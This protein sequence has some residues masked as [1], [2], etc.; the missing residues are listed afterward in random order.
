MSGYQISIRPLMGRCKE[1]KRKPGKADRGTPPTV[2]LI[3]NPPI[4][5]TLTMTSITPFLWF[6]NN[7][8]QAV[9]FY[10]SV[11][12]NA[13]AIASRTS[14]M[15]FVLRSRYSGENRR[16]LLRAP[17]HS[18]DQGCSAVPTD[19]SRRHRRCQSNHH[20]TSLH[21]VSCIASPMPVTVR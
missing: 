16:P 8:P 5:K 18:Y 14:G 17:G 2:G 11:F 1:T 13:K 3:W 20:H 7:V 10:K 19:R 21:L 12:P 6:D 15:D 9:A 4:A